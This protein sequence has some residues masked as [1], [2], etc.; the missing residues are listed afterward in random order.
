MTSQ[1]KRKYYPDDEIKTEP[2]SSSVSVYSVGRKDELPARKCEPT[3]ETQE[4]YDKV[5]RIQDGTEP[6][7][8]LQYRNI[9]TGLC[10]EPMDTGFL[11]LPTHSRSPTSPSPSCASTTYSIRQA[12]GGAELEEDRPQKKRRAMRQ[13]PLDP[14]DRAQAALMRKI[15]ACSDCK[16]RKVKVSVQ[17]ACRER[18]ARSLTVAAN[19]SANTTRGSPSRGRI[20]WRR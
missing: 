2:T 13:G 5:R 11:P 9:I 4:L 15:G 17:V 8:H 18:R 20:N 7:D 19:S 10:D 6:D 1:Q 16:A 12:M 3:M 14:L